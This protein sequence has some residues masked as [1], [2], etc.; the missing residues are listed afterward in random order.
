MDQIGDYEPMNYESFLRSLPDE[1]KE[2]AFAC[3]YRCIAFHNM[4]QDN[5][6][7]GE[8]RGHLLR[9]ADNMIKGNNGK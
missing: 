9:V 4:T 7:I 6:T 1:L 8:Q 5:T 3:H 2:L